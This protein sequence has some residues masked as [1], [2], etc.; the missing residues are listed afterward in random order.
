[1]SFVELNIIAVANMKDKSD[2]EGHIAQ[3]P[4]FCSILCQTIDLPDL[5]HPPRILQIGFNAGHSTLAILQS[6]PNCKIVSVDLG[7]H[8][9]T[10]PCNEYISNLFPEQHTLII[11]NSLDVLPT[12][13]D[14][15]FDIFFIDGGHQYETAFKDLENCY[16]IAQR[17]GAK[18]VIMDDV[19]RFLPEAQIISDAGFSIGPTKAWTEFLSNNIILH[20]GQ[21]EHKNRGM[22]T[23]LFLC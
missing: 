8:G 16:D 20:V 2:Q 19:I 22:A 9:Y 21:F 18:C 23:G 14:E 15:V 12:L 5:P 10:L 1:M 11:G 7:E 13:K 6:H 17:G 4:Y 3:S